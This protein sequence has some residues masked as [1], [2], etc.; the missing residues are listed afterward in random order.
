MIPAFKSRSSNIEYVKNKTRTQEDLKIRTVTISPIPTICICG[1]MNE[2]FIKIGESVGY[3]IIKYDVGWRNIVE[4]KHLIY[5]EVTARLFLLRMMMFNL[6]LSYGVPITWIHSHIL[7]INWMSQFNNIYVGKYNYY[8]I[9][10]QICD[11]E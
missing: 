4:Y 2:D 10:R 11:S 9:W 3:N 5:F 1:E 6:G 8:K 7:P